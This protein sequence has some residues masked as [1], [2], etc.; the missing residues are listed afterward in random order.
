MKICLLTTTFPR[1]QK[2]VIPQFLFGLANAMVQ[3]GAKVSVVAPHDQDTLDYEMMDG[4]EIHRFHYWW[5]KSAQGLAY[6]SG[7]PENVRRKKWI[8]LQFPTLEAAFLSAALRYG[9]DADVY[10]PHWT[11]AALPTVLASKINHKPVVTHA[12]SAEYV[13][14]ALHPLNRFIVNNSQAVISISRYAGDRVE[15]VVQ[16]VNHHIIGYGV[17][18]D[19]IASPDFD[20]KSFRQSLH[21]ENDRFLIFAVGRLVERKGY[22]VLIDAIAELLKRGENVRLLLGG[23]GPLHQE[24]QS[25]IEQLNIQEQAHLIGYVSDENLPHYLKAADVVIMPSV[26]DKTGDT[27]G[28]GI[29]PLEAMAN[30]TAVIASAIG[31]ILDVVEHEERGLLVEPNNPLALADAIVRLKND[32][33]LRQKVIAGGYT[34]VKGEFSWQSLARR[35]LDV[36]ENAISR[37]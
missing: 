10:N 14:K 12:Y 2:D 5:P 36:F 22:S 3:E 1:Y 21:I 34:F 11:F 19:K 31:G 37:R 20:A 25:Q 35:T 17:N 9:A 18:A 6:G 33:S 13:P 30:G 4:V 23:K 8:A 26:Y 32:D 7:I 24:L 28:L 15:K 16:P 29:P 27:E